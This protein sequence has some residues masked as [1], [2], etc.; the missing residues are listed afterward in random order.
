MY[1]FVSN[2]VK[3]L[4][5]DSI[6]GG[7]KEDADLP[8]YSLSKIVKSTCNFSIANKLGEGGFGPVYKVKIFR[9]E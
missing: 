5:D 3:D 6:C 8:S 1:H 2:P 9:N 7:P 4:N